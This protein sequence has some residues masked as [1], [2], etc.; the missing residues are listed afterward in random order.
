M[1]I[2]MSGCIAT[3]SGSDVKMGT[4]YRVDIPHFWVEFLIPTELKRGYGPFR[5]EV[6]FENP[7][8]PR[9]TFSFGNGAY[10]QEVGTLFLGVK[11]DFQDWDLTTEISIIKFDGSQCSMHSVEELAEFA[12]TFLAKKYFLANGTEVDDLGCIIT[13]KIGGYDVVVATRADQYHVRTVK[14]D[15]GGEMKTSPYQLYYI[16]LDGEVTVC[17]RVSYDNVKKLNPSWY[18]E[19]HAR[20]SK[21]IETMKVE[22]K[23]F[24]AGK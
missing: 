12:R 21:I 19:S 7:A 18:A 1:L 3:A 6:T 20:I 14:I 17:I 13:D 15:G 16:R 2:A 11:G 22:Q 10:R 23:S 24:S 4:V 9:F 5:K 8:N